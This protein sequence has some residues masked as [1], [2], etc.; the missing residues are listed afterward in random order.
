MI[1]TNSCVVYLGMLQVKALQLK[2]HKELK[3]QIEVDEI[4]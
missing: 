3:V 1:Y 4:A 2:T